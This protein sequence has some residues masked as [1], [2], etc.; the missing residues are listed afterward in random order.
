MLGAGSRTAVEFQRAWG[1]VAGEARNIWNYLGL[2][3]SGI[4][5]DTVEGMGGSSVDGSSRTKMVQQLEGLRH[6]M[7]GKGLKAHP[8]REARPV[9]VFQNVSDDKC[10]GSWLLSI[11][12]QG[13]TLSTKVF[14]EAMSPQP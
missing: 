7:I 9:T 1:A 14:R 10:A 2:E 3:P 6:L 11:P 8:E 12:A 13:N 5:A 4:L